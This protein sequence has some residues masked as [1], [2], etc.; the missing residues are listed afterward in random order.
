LTGE[1]GEDLRFDA[2]AEP[3]DSDIDVAAPALFLSGGLASS[4]RL[5]IGLFL[6]LIDFDDFRGEQSHFLD[7][8]DGLVLAPDVQGA[9]AFLPFGI[10]GHVTEFRHKRVL[11]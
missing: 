7:A 3:G 5:F 6:S 9:F 2:A 10:H 4:T 11:D 1:G 8:I